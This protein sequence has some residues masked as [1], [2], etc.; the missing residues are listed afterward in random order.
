MLMELFNK[1]KPLII[2]FLPL[3][4]YFN[5]LLSK[6]KSIITRKENLKFHLLNY[7]KKNFVRFSLLLNFNVPKNRFYFE[8]MKISQMYE[9]RY[10]KTNIN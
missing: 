8:F 4:I 3:K 6:F 10:L 7:L 1:K 5:G 2:L 9:S